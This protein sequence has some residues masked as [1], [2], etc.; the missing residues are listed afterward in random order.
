MGGIENLCD[1]R[2]CGPYAKPC[3]FYHGLENELVVPRSRASPD[4][5]V[6]SACNA[7]TCAALT[8]HSA[9][10]PETADGT[11]RAADNRP[12]TQLVCP[13]CAGHLHLYHAEAQLACAFFETPEGPKR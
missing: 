12:C 8:Q 3:A 10:I 6:L 9:A 1:V 13:K 2:I 4:R 11:Q 7:R 5:C